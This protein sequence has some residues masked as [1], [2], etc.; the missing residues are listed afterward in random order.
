MAC[1]LCKMYSSCAE[2]LF[3]Y[4]YGPPVGN[5]S[6]FFYVTYSSV[7]FGL[8]YIVLDIVWLEMEI[9]L[10]HFPITDVPLQCSMVNK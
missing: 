1:K 9:L 5:H 6:Y 4:S 8:P 10:Y 3:L 7:T 2:E